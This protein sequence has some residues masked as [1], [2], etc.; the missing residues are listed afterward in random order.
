MLNLRIRESV[1]LVNKE[2]TSTRTYIDDIG[3][4]RRSALS[5]YP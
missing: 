3:N 5:V 2:D 4:K 1:Y